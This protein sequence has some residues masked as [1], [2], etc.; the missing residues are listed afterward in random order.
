MVNSSR[1]A[2][3][4]AF[5]RE[6]EGILYRHRNNSIGNRVV[7]HLYEDL[8][9]HGESQK[10]ATR[11]RA[12]MRVLNPKN[13]SPGIIAR[14]GDGSFGPIV[15]ETA[16]HS[17]PGFA[18]ARGSTAG[19]EIGTEIKIFAKSMSKQ[20]GRVIP[21]LND[22]AAQFRKKSNEA[23]TIGI[24]GVN[25]ADQYV[26]YERD[27]TYPTTGT[28]DAPHPSQEAGATIAR[29]RREVESKF[30][31]FLVLRFRA[32]NV[33]PHPFAWVSESEAVHEYAAMVARVAA[34]YERRF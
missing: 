33:T 25:H 15:P 13:K 16:A 23:I 10:F 24:V 19:I 1:F 3:L 34:L 26:S 31:E 28:S 8:L 11:V 30:D 18:V 7:E 14:R 12:G 17:V 27:T 21:V 5:R 2:L 29:L 20:V 9:T 32:T 4:Q 22:Q 6:F